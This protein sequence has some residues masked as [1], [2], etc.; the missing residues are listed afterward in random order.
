MSIKVSVIMPAF[1]S[2]NH[3][4][5]AIYSVLN[6]SYS[7][8]ELLVV[9]GGSTDGT[10]GLINNISSVDDRVIY[11]DNIDDDGP[12]HARQVG[13]QACK[14]DYIAFLD[15]DDFWLPVKIEAQ[16]NFMLLK[17]VDFSYTR[18]RSIDEEG[19]N[20]S[21]PVL[22]RNKYNLRDALIYRGI[23]ILTVLL[24]RELLT[25]PVISSRSPFAEDYLWWLLILKE[26]HIAHLV[27]IDTAR[28]R[29]SK[30][31]RS[32]NRFDHQLSLWRI[33]RG[34]LQINYLKAFIYYS[35]YLLNTAFNKVRVFLCSTFN[36][37]SILN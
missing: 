33:Y 14:G 31:S 16:L 13:V 5:E 10:V 34:T 9:D 37:R 28:Y 6:Q 29:N 8:L 21:C 32:N 17:D 35:Y 36:N 18:Y 27:N 19:G 23:G 20:L 11:I 7:N 30:N 3:I 25:D 24:K 12:A 2:C 15:A 4:E 26:G 22:M 1:N